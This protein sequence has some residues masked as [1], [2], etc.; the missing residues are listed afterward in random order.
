MNLLNNWQRRLSS[1]SKK[2]E[3]L[4]Y[5]RKQEKIQ[6]FVVDQGAAAR[7]ARAPRARGKLRIKGFK[8][9]GEGLIVPPGNNHSATR[10]R[11]ATLL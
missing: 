5:P 1:L 2:K 3:I 4:C 6:C 8:Y 11:T 10:S 7:S 9:L